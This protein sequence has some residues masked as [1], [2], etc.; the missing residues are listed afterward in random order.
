MYNRDEIAASGSV[1]SNFLPAE[2]I[3]RQNFRDYPELGLQGSSFCIV[4]PPPEAEVYA[5][6]RRGMMP[7]RNL[8]W[9][10]MWQTNYLS[11][12]L[13]FDSTLDFDALY[14]ECNSLFYGK[15]WEGGMKAFRALLTKAFVETPG[16]MGWGLGAPLGR[17]LDEPGVWQEL[18]TLL[19][20]A[21]Q[22]AAEDPDPR[23]LMHVQRER[24][25]FAYTWEA[26]RVAYLASYR[27][28]TAY[29]VTA[30]ITIDGILDE[31]DWKA[32]DVMTGFTIPP[33]ADSAAKPEPTYFRVAYE[34]DNVY[35]AVEAMEPNPAAIIADQIPQDGP[36]QKVGNAV[37]VFLNYPD[38]AEE[39]YHYIINSAGS[40][41]DARHGPNRRDLDYNANVEYAVKTSPDRW[42][43]EMRVP[44]AEIGMKCFDGSTWRMNIARCRKVREDRSE[45][46]SWCSGHFHGID[47]FGVVRF[48]PTRPTG[49]SQGGDQAAWKNASLNEV[50]ENATLHPARQWKEGWKTS[51]VP[52]VWTAD[53]D[54]V[55]ST[56]LHPDSAD[57][58]FVELEKGIIGNWYVAPASK[59][60]ITFRASGHGK[61]RLWTGKYEKAKGKGYPFK[62]S[63]G[64]LD[65]DVQSDQWQTY[66]LEVDKGGEPRLY[67]RFFHQ[68]GIVRIDD[69]VVTPVGEGV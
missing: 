7:E 21:E 25:I 28:L 31:K 51:L 36:Y 58:Y 27:E 34:P 66:S 4:P 1:G 50:T 10:A 62:G 2:R 57:N 55:G 18:K 61:A 52:K 60:R 15:G 64:V 11:A 14:E 37:E 56:R 19:A 8:Q 35:I 54:A 16:C 69:V 26:A 9:A 12:Q 3:L 39:Y 20:K 24:D 5:P 17:C 40:I 13:M 68:E 63:T 43:L 44:T 32:A 33:W 59:L 67:V 48:T 22:A 46:S 47:N 49:L 41:I 53:R 23:A 38:M 45:L 30:P 6:L 65:F 29:R 42:T